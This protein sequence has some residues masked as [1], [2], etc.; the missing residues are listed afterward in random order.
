MK[1][2]TDLNTYVSLVLLKVFTCNS[3]FI[4]FKIFENTIEINHLEFVKYI[5]VNIITRNDKITF[6]FVQ[7]G[8]G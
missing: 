2:N 6:S 8:A 4:F 1:S 5:G 3:I 7:L